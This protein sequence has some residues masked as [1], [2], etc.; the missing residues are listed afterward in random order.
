MERP[1]APALA[2][3]VLIALLAARHAAASI[4]TFTTLDDPVA[5]VGSGDST[6]ALGIYAN[7][8]VGQSYV[9]EYAISFIETG[10]DYATLRYPGS[11][12]T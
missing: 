7:I 8:V 9:P 5:P 1:L 11:V 10:G 3:A 6:V 4:Y 2:I 12:Q